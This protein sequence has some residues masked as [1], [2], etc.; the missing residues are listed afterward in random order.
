MEQAKGDVGAGVVG[1]VAL[2]GSA[3]SGVHT[4]MVA[5]GIGVGSGRAG[6]FAVKVGGIVNGTSAKPSQPP[7]Q[8]ASLTR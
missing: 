3:G 5:V 7:T 6:G 1:S 4:G 8:S 2:V